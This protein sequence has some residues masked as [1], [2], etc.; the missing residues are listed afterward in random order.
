MK[1]LPFKD[2]GRFPSLPP[3][4]LGRWQGN[5][6]VNSRFPIRTWMNIFWGNETAKLN[7]IRLPVQT[8]KDYESSK[9]L[10]PTLSSLQKFYLDFLESWYSNK[11]FEIFRKFFF[12]FFV[13][14]FACVK[15]FESI[16]FNFKVDY[17]LFPIGTTRLSL[18]NFFFFGWGGGRMPKKIYYF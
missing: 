12:F 7:G 16:N 6:G 18:V 14:L 2:F 13:F 3:S 8:R 10:I 5:A 9:I 4:K 1:T 15:S 11:K 17:I